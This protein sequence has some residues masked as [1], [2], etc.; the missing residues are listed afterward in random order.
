[1]C[2]RPI[3]RQ[4]LPRSGHATQIDYPAIRETRTR[5]DNQIPHRTRHEDLARAGLTENPRR[6][7]HGYPPDIGLQQFA[8]TRVDAFA[9][10]DSQLL[11]V[12]AQC[13]GAADGLRRAVERGEVAVP[14]ALHHRAAESFDEIGRDLAETHQDGPPA[15]I[16]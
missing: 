3:D 1:V 11:G 2:T 16:A 5:S 13:L 15:L 14:G 8:L 7:V 12:I 4:E 9:D 6:D 10:L